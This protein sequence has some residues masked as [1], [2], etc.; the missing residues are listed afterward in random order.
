MGNEVSVACCQ[1]E[2]RRPVA[3]LQGRPGETARPATTKVQQSSGASNDPPGPRPESELSADG[4]LV[5][6]EALKELQADL[7]AK[8]P[9]GWKDKWQ[10]ADNL[11][12]SLQ[13]RVSNAQVESR[14]QP[15]RQP[16]KFERSFGMVREH[17]AA[18]H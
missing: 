1:C 8:K 6:I 11:R 12:L 4:M 3:V 9:P 5:R 18:C 7:K 2:P 14:Q 13:Q 15:A 10:E 17:T 16:V